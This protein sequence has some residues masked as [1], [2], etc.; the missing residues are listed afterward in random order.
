MY[1]N[2]LFLSIILFFIFS[3]SFAQTTF[4]KSYSLGYNAEGHAVLALVDGYAFAGVATNL[5]EDSNYVFLI[6]TD[7]SGDTLWTRTFTSKEIFHITPNN[8]LQQATDGGFFITGFSRNTNE[9]DSLCLL[10]TDMNGNLLWIKTIGQAN[11]FIDGTTIEHTLDSGYIVAGNYFPL[12]GEFHIY[13]LKINTNGD[14][15]WSK[16]MTVDND[17]NATS[18]KPTAD[19]GYIITGQASWRVYLIKTNSLGNVQWSM[20]YS[21]DSPYDI[22]YAVQQTSDGGYIISGTTNDSLGDSRMI[23]IK[24]KSDGDTL[25][26]RTYVGNSSFLTAADGAAVLQT[27]EGGFVVAGYTVQGASPDNYSCLLKT[28][29]LGNVLWARTFD[30]IPGPGKGCLAIKQTSDNGFI[31]TGDGTEAFLIKTD[32]MGRVHCSDPPLSIVTANPQIELILG[33]VSNANANCGISVPP[34]IVGSGSTVTMVC[35]PSDVNE[36]NITTSLQ[37]FPN[38]A[39][40]NFTILFNEEWA[41]ENVELKI[42]DIAGREVHQQRIN[43]E[44]TNVYFALA[45][46]LYLVKVNAEGKE[47]MEKLVVN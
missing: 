27:N 41:E 15:L 10:R 2:S 13:L 21:T 16:T 6:K 26:T 23:L 20:I 17:A 36:I 1:K 9:N 39:Y 14:T 42:F 37:L 7:F 40:D 33:F 11:T 25:W 45:S 8:S 46:G 3:L 28:D 47:W 5:A 32:S 29:S 12:T 38:P 18:V 31:I 30:I 44:G 19:G 43:P 34:V 22:G 4:H 24:T 35:D